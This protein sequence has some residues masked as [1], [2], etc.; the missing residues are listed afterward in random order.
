MCVAV[1]SGL[2]VDPGKRLMGPALGV[3]LG[4]YEGRRRRTGCPYF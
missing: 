1:L 3:V 4:G 2:S